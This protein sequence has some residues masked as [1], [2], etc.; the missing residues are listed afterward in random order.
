MSGLFRHNR[1]KRTRDTQSGMEYQS[2]NAA[3]K[4]VA[5]E[6][7]LPVTDY[8]WFDVLRLSREGRF[9]DIE[10]GRVILRTGRLADI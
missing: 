8:V 6:F 1:P 2:R 5:P 10:T 3:G 7:G 9:A 4:A